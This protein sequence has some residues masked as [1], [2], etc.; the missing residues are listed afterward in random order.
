[1]PEINVISDENKS[2]DK[3]Y[4]ENINKID[5]KLEKIDDRLYKIGTDFHKDFGSMNQN[6]QDLLLV[7]IKSEC[8]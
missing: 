2:L 4:T 6:M 3:K 7:L 1:M 5:Q 8:K